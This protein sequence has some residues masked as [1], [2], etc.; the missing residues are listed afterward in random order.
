MT[1]ALKKGTIHLPRNHRRPVLSCLALPARQHAD[2]NANTVA[3]G[4]PSQQPAMQQGPPQPPSPRRPKRGHAALEA[5][6]ATHIA[7]RHLPERGDGGVDLGV[8]DHEA[9]A[10]VM[11][12]AQQAQAGVA[13]PPPEV[14]EPPPTRDGD[15]QA[16]ASHEVEDVS[17]FPSTMAMDE[18]IDPVTRLRMTCLPVLDLFVCFILSG[19]S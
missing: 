17:Y 19:R 4:E 3:T 12:S 5:S 13:A 18:T 6:D 8:L 2:H 1:R 14:I 7:K 16:E 9:F 15:D 10:R 11:A